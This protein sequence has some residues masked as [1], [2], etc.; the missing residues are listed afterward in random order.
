MGTSNQL[1]ESGFVPAYGLVTAKFVTHQR[2]AGGEPDGVPVNGRVVF[3][4]TTRVA[5]AGTRRVFVPAP[6][7]GWLRDG[8]LWDSPRGGNQGVRLMAP[9]RGRCLL[10][11]VTVWRRSCGMSRDVPRS[12]RTRAFMFARV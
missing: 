7:T 3:T 12:C 2:A 9:A 4:P 5:D 8:V 10:N 11:G 6:V 1:A